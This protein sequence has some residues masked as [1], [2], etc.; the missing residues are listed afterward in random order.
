[1]R[2]LTDSAWPPADATITRPLVN[3]LNRSREQN[4]EFRD[5]MTLKWQYNTDTLPPSSLTKIVRSPIGGMIGVPGEAFVGEGAIKE[6]PQGSMPRENFAIAD[7][8]DQD[9]SRSWALDSSQQGVQS[10]KS[11][12]ATAEQLQQA[13]ANARL[14]WERGIVLQWYV[15]GVTKFSTYILRYLPVEHAAQ[16]V[17]PQLAQIWDA[18]RKTGVNSALAFTAMPDS[19]LRVDQAVDRKT[20]QDL[21]S[22]LANDPYIQKGR[23]KLLEKLL[24]KFHIDPAG[25]VIPPDPPQPTP[26]DVSLSFKGEDMVAPQ[27]PIVLEIL[28]QLG[29]KFSEAA[30]MASQQALANAQM[31]AA[32]EAQQGE[33]K[34]DTKHGGKLPQQES[35]SKHAADATG[36]MQNT[37][38]P[39]AM[40]AAGGMLQ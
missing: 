5:A 38:A 26:K 37:G 32:A 1:M 16:I 4:L 3:E 20:A 13:N 10:G 23:A 36:G 22:F 7:H 9:I 28:Q 33:Q 14:D 27:A 39:A 21:Y 8:I 29:F 30:I 31:M 11:Q 15:K 18:W 17:G 34:G 19:A 24:R 35:L 25:I 2:T 40:G 12:T 6:L